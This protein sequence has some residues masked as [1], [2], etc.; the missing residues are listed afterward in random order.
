MFSQC[1][2]KLMLLHCIDPLEIWRKEVAWRGKDQS[3]ESEDHA[4]T[5]KDMYLDV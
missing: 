2:F 1:S 5:A 4:M 3:F